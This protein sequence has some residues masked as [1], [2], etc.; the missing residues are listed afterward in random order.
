MDNLSAYIC[1][2][3]FSIEKKAEK[4]LPFKKYILT[5]QPRKKVSRV[6]TLDWKQWHII[7]G[8]ESRL[9]LFLHKKPRI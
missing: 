5:L 2:V 1:S 4:I 7:A 6:R 9:P 3:I 8:F